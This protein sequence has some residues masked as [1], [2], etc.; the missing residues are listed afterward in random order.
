MYTPSGQLIVGLIY[1][2]ITDILT[3]NS[4][5]YNVGDKFTAVNTTYTGNGFAVEETYLTDLS[6]EEY[7][8]QNIV[9]PE[10]IQLL[11][12]DIEKEKSNSEIVYPEQIQL[13][14]ISIESVSVT[15]L[16]YA[17]IIEG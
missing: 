11:N 14:N 1:Y 8:Y 4:V 17:I 7:E 13:L 15:N 12:I 16:G 10:Q 2:V 6:I 5:T 9:F 3:H